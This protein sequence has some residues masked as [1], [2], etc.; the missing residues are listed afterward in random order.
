MSGEAMAA[1]RNVGLTNGDYDQERRVEE[2]LKMASE[3]E[4][5]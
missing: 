5:K 1:S 4:D 2:V 3:M